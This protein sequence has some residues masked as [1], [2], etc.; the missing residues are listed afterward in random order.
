MLAALASALRAN[1]GLSLSHNRFV[2]FPWLSAA[3]KDMLLARVCCT[4]ECEVLVITPL[5]TE[6]S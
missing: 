5:M 2:I 4:A 3:P 1:D 6:C